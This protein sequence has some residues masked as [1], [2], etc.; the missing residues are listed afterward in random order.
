ML[1]KYEEI[2]SEIFNYNLEND[3]VQSLVREIANPDLR[4]RKHTFVIPEILNDLVIP[5]LKKLGLEH[6]VPELQEKLI[7]AYKKYGEDEK[8]REILLQITESDEQ[9]PPKL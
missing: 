6:L 9:N 3:L 8:L 4:H 2:D 7:E 1:K 5:D